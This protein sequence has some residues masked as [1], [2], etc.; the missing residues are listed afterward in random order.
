MSFGFSG[1]K[2]PHFFR[3]SDRAAANV[4][5]VAS[6]SCRNAEKSGL[7]S[8]RTVFSNSEI[9]ALS[10]PKQNASAIPVASGA[11]TARRKSFRRSD[12]VRYGQFEHEIDASAHGAFRSVEFVHD[13]RF[14][15]LNE[16]SAHDR[17]YAV[18]TEFSHLRNMVCVTVVKG[19]VFRRRRKNHLLSPAII[20]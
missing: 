9:S 6:S 19:I 7:S 16:T 12:G 1:T 18:R 11:D 15:A 5:P 4:F 14:S 8:V 3:A 20:K 13:R 2:A 10:L 17:D